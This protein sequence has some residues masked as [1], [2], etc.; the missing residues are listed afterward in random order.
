MKRPWSRRT[1]L[2]LA[3]AAVVATAAVVL[4]RGD[5]TDDLDLGGP[6]LAMD[7]HQVVRLQLTTGGVPYRFVRRGASLWTMDGAVRD[8][9]D[10]VSL[11]QQLAV[12]GQAEGGRVLP[13]TEPDDRRYD[14]NGP[15]GVHLSLWDG[16]GHEERLSLGTVNPVTG[17]VYATGA[18]RPA[19][20][21]V[22]KEIRDRLVRLPEAVRL[23]TLLPPVP[24]A[25]LDRITVVRDRRTDVLK[26][27]D[28]RWWLKVASVDEPLVPSLVRDWQ[29]LYDDRRRRDDEG[30]WLL[31]DARKA[32]LLAYEVGQEQVAHFVPPG[33]AAA[34]LADWELD[35][36]WLQVVLHGA[37]I[38]PDSTT[39]DP[40]ELII[41]FGTPLDDKTLPAVRRGNPLVAPMRAVAT[42]ESPLGDLFYPYALT[43][44][45][46]LADEI[47]LAG[48]RGPVLRLRR[49]DREFRNDRR[50]Q[51]D[52]LLPAPETDS[53]HP[54]LIG[55]D[56]V[57]DLDRLPV[58]AVLPPTDAKRVLRDEGRLTLTITWQAPART[59]VWQCGRLDPDNVPGGAERLAPTDDGEGPIGLWR[60]ADG[61]L[62]QVPSTVF[63]AGRNLAR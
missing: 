24:F 32:A 20:F 18:G 54:Q 61:R 26:A 6:L 31:A 47:E 39:G 12:L 58:L 2:M 29:R 40:D 15:Q 46:L 33:R 7:L 22:L 16:D 42:L 10:P 25:A 44:R 37:A 56:F 9:V 48:A 59:E 8:W 5:T 43:G 4:L 63:V 55:R 30:L 62:L 60:P 45:P 14:F 41:G 50:T 13:G 11:A 27:A 1:L 52:Q 23:S 38:D 34:A 49:T 53:R 3:L 17:N 21:P 36:P 35:P 28:G 51:W 19:C 57:V